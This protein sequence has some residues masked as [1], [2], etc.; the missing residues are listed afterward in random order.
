[1]LNQRR[2]HASAGPF[3]IP[4]SAFSISLSVPESKLLPPS[5]RRPSTCRRARHRDPADP[6]V[7]HEDHAA[8]RPA[9][10]DDGL[11]H[12]KTEEDH[13]SEH[14]EDGQ[15]TKD[16][17]TTAAGEMR[18]LHITSRYE[19]QVREGHAMWAGRAG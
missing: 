4:H 15:G 1:M 19:D 18:L 8:L 10:G 2:R 6:V 3:S 5:P 12:A 17:V 7:G 14:P 13:R 9:Q 16:R 11:P